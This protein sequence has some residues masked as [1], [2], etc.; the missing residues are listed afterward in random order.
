MPPPPADLTASRLEEEALRLARHGSFRAAAELCRTLTTKHPQ[1]ASGW[2]SASTIALQTGD[3][4]AALAAIDRALALEPK[5]GRSLLQKARCLRVLRRHAEALEL[6]RSIRHLLNEDAAG[7][8]ALGTLFSQFGEQ[9]LA[10]ETYD[11]AL[12]LA[13]RNAAFAFNRASA[14]RSLGQLAAAEED[15]DAVIKAG[16]TTSRPTRIART[17]ARRRPIATMS[18]SSKKSWSGASATGVAKLRSAMRWP[19]NMRTWGN[20]PAPGRSS[21]KGRSC[22][23]GISSITSIAMSR[24]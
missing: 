18:P 23:A 7:L 22:A 1:F 14:R 4:P 5:D 20:M 15:Y 13:P 21:S 10:L 9:Q 17:C 2:R 11:R 6:A 16:P 24:P 8:D 12:Q 19:R 3:A